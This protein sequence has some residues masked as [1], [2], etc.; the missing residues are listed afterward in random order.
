MTLQSLLLAKC[1]FSLLV[2]G[3]GTEGL[4]FFRGFYQAVSLHSMEMETQ[5][6]ADFTR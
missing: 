3:A 5:K 2:P 1:H 6:G 4:A